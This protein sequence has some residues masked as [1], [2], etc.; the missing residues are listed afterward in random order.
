[1]FTKESYPDYKVTFQKPY[2]RIEIIK[3]ENIEFSNSFINWISGNFDLFLQEEFKDKIIIYFPNGFIKIEYFPTSNKLKII[4]ENKIRNNSIDL[5][6]KVFT[7]Y[8]NLKPILL[9]P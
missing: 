4:I 5:Y 2:Y 7:I 1:M 9:L 3:I 6:Y 8:N